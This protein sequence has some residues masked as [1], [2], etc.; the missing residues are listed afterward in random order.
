[1]V[2][3]AGRL[4]V[5][6]GDSLDKKKIALE[7]IPIKQICDILFNN[8]GIKINA[9]INR[10]IM[11]VNEDLDREYKDI[12]P[13]S[14]YINIM[15]SENPY[16]GNKKY[17]QAKLLGGIFTSNPKIIDEDIGDT[18]YITYYYHSG[19]LPWALKDEFYYKI[20]VKSDANILLQHKGL[21]AEVDTPKKGLI[22]DIENIW[23]NFISYADKIPEA[24]AKDI[25]AMK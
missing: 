13:T 4:P 14:S 1:M 2:K 7:K 17:D 15:L 10:T 20:T 22:I 18:I 3:V 9:D 23:N 5:P 8:Y 12:T 25:K 6:S 16:L 21:V 11:T 24:L 19:G